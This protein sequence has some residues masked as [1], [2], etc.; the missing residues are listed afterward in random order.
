MNTVF[1]IL[2]FEDEISWFRME[3]NRIKAILDKHYL[4]SNI[5]RKNGDDFTEGEIIGNKYDLILM[6]FKL[7]D[8]V[9]GDQIVSTIR[10]NRV[11]T[12]IL[13]YSSEEQKMLESIR[14]KLPLIDGIYLAKRDYITF[15]EKV[16]GLISKIVR[17]TE[18]IVNL[19]GFVMDGSCDFELRIKEILNIAWHKFS[20]VEK[21]SLDEAALNNISSIEKRQ[22]KTKKK[23]VETPPLFL[24]AVNGKYFFSH[25][26]RLSLLTRVIDILQKNYGLEENQV[27]NSFKSCY[28]NEISA[29]RN[30]L[31]HRKASD[32]CIEIKGKVIS[33]DERLHQKMR[34]KIREYD[35]IISQ[36]EQ[37]VT[38]EM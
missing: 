10:Q 14:S 11:L 34:T 17:R 33:V 36:L 19:R 27:L 29:Y 26:D 37:F 38:N 32:N 12:D 9:T 22:K 7:A 4:E 21:D 16:E 31:G 1:N 28:E 25:S 35:M 18:D 15:T 30:A 24:S 23:V 20:D 3:E 8:D 5:C 2:W 13:F 6:D